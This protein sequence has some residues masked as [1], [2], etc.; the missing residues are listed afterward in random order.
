MQK[1]HFTFIT[2]NEIDILI[3]NKL[4]VKYLALYYS[5]KIFIIFYKIF[6][7]KTEICSRQY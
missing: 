5:F 2:Y 4:Y 6:F 3:A 1:N 7:Y